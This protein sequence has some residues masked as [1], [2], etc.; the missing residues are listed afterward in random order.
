MPPK[1]ILCPLN[2]QKHLRSDKITLIVMTYGAHIGCVLA[3]YYMTAIEAEPTAF[4]VGDKH[5]TVFHKCGKCREAVAVLL[6][7]F[8]DL[9]KG[10]RNGEVALKLRLVAKALVN[11]LI[12]LVFVVLCK[13]KKIR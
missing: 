5:L 9:I 11:I 10:V 12:F 13:F 4:H 3:I 7:Y 6:L 1:D 8:R 2:V